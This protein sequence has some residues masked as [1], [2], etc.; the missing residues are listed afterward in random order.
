[1]RLNRLWWAPWLVGS[2]LLASCGPEYVLDRLAGKPFADPP[3]AEAKGTPSLRNVEIRN[4]VSLEKGFPPITFQPNYVWF[5][6]P[7]MQGE[8]RI[9]RNLQK[10]GYQEF[11]FPLTEVIENGQSKGRLGGEI[12]L[13]VL[14]DSARWKAE[15]LVVLSNEEEANPTVRHAG[16][17]TPEHR[18]WMGVIPNNSEL[19]IQVR[20][21][22]GISPDLKLAYTYQRRDSNTLQTIDA[23][24]GEGLPLISWL[25]EVMPL[26]EIKLWT[27]GQAGGY[28][29]TQLSGHPGMQGQLSIH[30][31]G[32]QAGWAVQV[33]Q[34]AATGVAQAD[35]DQ[36]DYLLIK[37]AERI[38]TPEHPDVQ[39]YLMPGSRVVFKAKATDGLNLNDLS[40]RLKYEKVF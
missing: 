32:P 36:P 33:L 6:Q 5:N 12:T 2:V 40:A 39:L 9:W 30:I 22:D 29:I 19:V 31:D 35:P 10:G 28:T 38:I 26:G 21:E 1:M 11:L 20:A 7:I 18:S 25:P 34:I 3:A 17:L 37:E 8:A 4:P 13:E 15:V 27:Q 24:G 16:L 23:S 14:G